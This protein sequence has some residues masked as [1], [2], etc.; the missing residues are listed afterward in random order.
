MSS[1]VD[2]GCSADDLKNTIKGYYNKQFRVTPEVTLECELDDK[3][4]T[5]DCTSDNVAEH[6]YTIKVPKSISKAS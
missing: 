5:P 6:I 3:T 2:A 4:I 1:A